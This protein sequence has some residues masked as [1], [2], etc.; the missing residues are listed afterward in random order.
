MFDK[1]QALADKIEQLAEK[2]LTL[3][4]AE[5]VIAGFV[6]VKSTRSINIGSQILD[7]F[8]TGKGNSGKTQYDLLNGVTE[9]YTHHSKGSTVKDAQSKQVAT[10]EF[11]SAANKKVE[12]FDWLTNDKL[13]ELAAKGE[14]LLN[15]NKLSLV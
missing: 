3:A 11:G 7:L 8:Q 9:F 2:P 5:K 15:E 1:R 13:D 4:Q 10:S 12:F 14:A 6:D